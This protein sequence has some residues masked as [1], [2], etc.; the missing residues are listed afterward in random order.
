MFTNI[1][2]ERL[3]NLLD[4]KGNVLVRGNSSRAASDELADVVNTALNRSET[5]RDYLLK[6]HEKDLSQFWP[7]MGSITDEASF[8]KESTKRDAFVNAVERVYKETGDW[9]KSVNS[10]LQQSGT[11][12]VRGTPK[13]KPKSIY[14]RIY[15][16]L[17]DVKV[18]DGPTK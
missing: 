18:F 15:T 11:M 2:L 17:Y 1:E 4:D 6:L 5:L 16:D 3:V 12:G 7:Q 13:F 10:V 9:S 14:D 8:I